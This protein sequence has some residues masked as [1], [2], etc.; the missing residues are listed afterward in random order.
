MFFG[1]W[2]M[3]YGSRFMFMVYGLWSMFDGL[4]F[5]VYGLCFMVYGL[6]FMVYGL[7]LMVYGLWFMN[8]VDHGSVFR[9][10]VLGLRV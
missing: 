7:W 4:W 3:V 9:F 2:C 1:V 6:R 8:E 5:M 10:Q